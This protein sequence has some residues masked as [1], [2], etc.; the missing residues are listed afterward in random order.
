MMKTPARS[1]V[2]VAGTVVCP[3]ITAAARARPLRYGT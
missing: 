1:H 3:A 2:V